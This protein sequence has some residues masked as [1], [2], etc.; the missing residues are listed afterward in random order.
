MIRTPIRAALAA[1]LLASQAAHA[2]EAFQTYDN[3]GGG[4]PIDTARWIDGERI[5]VIKRGALNLMQRT[6]GST[7]SSGGATFVNFNESFA[8]PAAVTAIKAKITVNALE[9]NACATNTALGQSRARIVGGFFNTGVP[10]PGSQ[11]GDVIAQIR[12]TRFSNSTDPAGVLQVQGFASICTSADCNSGT[13]IG[14]VVSLGTVALGQATTVQMQWDQPSKSFF[15]MR[16]NGAFSGS[17][18]YT[19]TDT[20]PPSVPFK[21][22]STRLDLP[23]CAGTAPIVGSVDAVFDNIAV[24]QSA[25]P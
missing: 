4:V 17:A 3:F 21:Q 11:L 13:T 9:V 20:S 1:A 8:N 12:L 16:D 19:D 6:W 2:L 7:Q 14:S 22:L 5:R 23:S 10:V 25:A 18:V 24:N 15:F